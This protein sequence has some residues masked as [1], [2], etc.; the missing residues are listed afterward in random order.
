MTCCRIYSSAAGKIN[1]IN[2]RQKRAIPNSARPPPGPQIGLAAS[3]GGGRIAYPLDIECCGERFTNG[4]GK[5]FVEHWE[6]HGWGGCVLYCRNCNGT[7]TGATLSGSLKG[8]IAHYKNCTAKVNN[9][10]TNQA[11]T[12]VLNDPMETETQVSNLTVNLLETD[13]VTDYRCAYCSSYYGS[14]FAGLKLHEHSAH[15]KEVNESRKNIQKKNVQWGDDDLL[16]LSSCELDLMD[17]GEIDGKRVNRQLEEVIS[18]RGWAT[19]APVTKLQIA[20]SIKY[21]R[22][23]H[24]YQRVFEE[25][26]E[27][28]ERKRLATR[29]TSSSTRSEPEREMRAE[30]EL[31]FTVPDRSQARAESSDP[32]T[33]RC[34]STLSPLEDLK[35]V[36]ERQMEDLERSREDSSF[37]R[38]LRDILDSGN[39]DGSLKLLTEMCGSE[40]REVEHVP[41]VARR[42]DRGPLKPGSRISRRAEKRKRFG[43]QQKQFKRNPGRVVDQILHGRVAIDIVP[44]IDEVET[45]YQEI[46]NNVSAAA[47]EHSFDSKPNADNDSLLKGFS[48]KEIADALKGMTYKSAEGPDKIKVAQLKSIDVKILCVVFNLWLLKGKIPDALRENRTILIPKTTSGLD[49]V[50]NWRPLTISSV[51]LRLYSK[52]LASRFMKSISL[53]TQQRGFMARNGCAENTFAVKTVLRRAK[54]QGVRLLLLDL[55][56][57]FDT[58]EHSS[59]SRALRRFGVDPHMAAIVID[60][61]T[62]I[63]TVIHVGGKQTSNIPIK[64]GVKQGDPLSPILFNMVIDEL[65]DKLGT[66][67]GFKISNEIILTCLG[68][69]DDLVLFSGST[70]GMQLLLDAC[71]QFFNDRGLKLNVK[72]C[73]G[74]NARWL[75]KEKKSV[76]DNRPIWR[77]YGSPIPMTDFDETAKYLGLNIT[78]SGKSAVNVDLLR[79]MLHAVEHCELR[80]SQKIFVIRAHIIPKFVYG[81]GLSITTKGSLEQIDIIIRATVKRL[82][83]MPDNLAHEFLYM[84]TRNGG[85]GLYRFAHKLPLLKLG[86]Y[87]K[88]ALSDNITREILKDPVWIKD[89][90]TQQQ[91]YRRL[92][93]HEFV[94]ALRGK[95]RLEER[96]FQKLSSKVQ[97]FGSMAFVND[98]IG[99]SWLKGYT[100]RWQGRRYVS[101][102]RL[103][104]NLVAT[105]EMRWR[106]RGTHADR[107]CRFGCNAVESQAHVLQA[108]HRLKRA[109]IKR[110]HL[111][112]DMVAKQASAS[113]MLVEKELVVKMP[114]M[115]TLRPDLVLRKGDEIKVVD[116]TVPYEFDEFSLRNAENRKHESYGILKDILLRKYPDSTTFS[117]VGFVIGA[118]G[119][120]HKGNNPFCKELNASVAWKRRLVRSVLDGS[121]CMMNKFG[122]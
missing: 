3:P 36:I 22:K 110:H 47:D 90:L 58:V 59:I 12:D 44:P 14:S 27:I 25:Q 35:I 109:R 56:K 115:T 85:L 112:V 61:Y 49:Q 4:T 117:T 69:A 108:C 71:I 96:D 54:Q 41:K 6:Q 64:R 77:A 81:L 10:G 43:E 18:S 34:N 28:R 38:V 106:G 40:T 86:L 100:P 2:T 89:V 17:S 87:A 83:C 60:M 26:R 111:I 102:L 113:G 19:T 53:N 92:T 70:I 57:A 97:G 11:G 75:G 99:N 122:T 42:R 39:I 119:A 116:V 23:N 50:G 101:A 51:I 76:I 7:G 13:T 63:S 9:Q 91:A 32:E 15:G 88:L 121:M 73:Q 74:V 105:N 65:I 80:R 94:S 114:D 107:L 68:Y 82:L 93:G 16:F 66:N 48:T 24:R 5:E 30:I 21:I 37:T 33:L 67:Y 98:Y 46:F 84:S 1:R 62:D 45:S 78:T 103:R 79:S 29:M 104:S 120:W 55:A 31:P 95:Q 8:R 52:T 72:K 118:R 20:E